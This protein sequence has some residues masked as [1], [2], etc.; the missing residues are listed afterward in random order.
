MNEYDPIPNEQPKKELQ[1]DIKPLEITVEGLFRIAGIL[2]LRDVYKRQDLTSSPPSSQ[3]IW[4]V[5]PESPP[6]RAGNWQQG[7]RSLL[8]LTKHLTTRADDG[9]AAPV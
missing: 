7:L 8:D 9:H 4:A 2:A 3:L 5:A 6:S 1:K